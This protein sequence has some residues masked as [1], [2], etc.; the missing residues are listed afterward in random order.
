M[1][2]DLNNTQ[3]VLGID[4]G[5]SG[6]KAILI[7]NSGKII[8]KGDKGY[9]LYTE[10]RCVEQEADDWWDACIT[11]VKQAVSKENA[12][13]VRAISLSTQGATM[14]ALD[15]K[16]K[17]IGRALT[18]M[19]TRAQE[20]AD[21]LE[22]IM[23]KD[24]VYRICGWRSG[25]SFDASK[26]LWMKN[27]DEYKEAKLYLST[28]E[29]INLKLT[30]KAVIDP[31]N[32]A[33]RQIYNVSTG[34]WAE[35]ILN[36]V[37]VSPGELPEILKTGALV[38]V[39]T[40]EA[41]V[42]LGL[43]KAVR[44]YNG[45]H[46]QYCASLGCGAVNDGDMFLSTGTTWVVMG[47]T[48]KPIFSDTYISACTHPAE[49]LYGNM[50]SLTGTG[51][52]YQWVKDTFL[53]NEAF[54]SIDEKAAKETTKCGNVFFFPWLSGAAYPI[55]NMN[56]RGG[57]IGMDFSHGPYCMALAVMES[58]AFSLKNAVKDFESHGF[59]P[60]AIKI[61][62][63]AAKSKVWLDIL[64]AVIDVPLYKMEI[65]DSCALGAAFIAAK[66]EG[67]YSD[68]ASAARAMVKQERIQEKTADRNFYIEKYE[69]YNRALSAMREI[70]SPGGVA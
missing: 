52:S 32:A 40:D 1:S 47:I 20:E 15:T 18:W 17:P 27:N 3:Y 39:L 9:R 2:L 26:I 38:G 70:Y 25:P 34:G 57:F 58:A 29:Y 28:I 30:G 43:D 44:V 66:S 68:Y 55:W 12:P 33:I 31:T 7:D 36:M 49:G 16:G 54:S 4:V 19:D 41:A 35:K 67:W 37:G 60:K 59:K 10:G 13:N 53:T 48:E 56:A 46:D 6:T 42:T 22:S 45:A 50:A 65:T 64:A 23:G 8:G 51:A 5:T 62:G 63:G 14:A 69:R 61:M 24:E 11:A 21:K